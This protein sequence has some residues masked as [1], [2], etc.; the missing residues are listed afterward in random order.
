MRYT[1]I[2]EQEPDG[3]YVVTVPAMPGCISQG[4][5]RA[6]ALQNIREAVE[7]P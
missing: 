5:T 4:D 1:A 6:A 3:G 2:L 7:V